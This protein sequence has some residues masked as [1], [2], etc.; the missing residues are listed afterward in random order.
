[1]QTI[2]ESLIKQ[3]EQVLRDNSE[4]MLNRHTNLLEIAIISLYNRLVNRIGIDTEQFRANGAVIAL[5][6]FGRGLIG[7]NEP[8]QI[9]FLTTESLPW[10]ETWTEE[11]HSPLTEAGWELIS[12]Q[13]TMG[14]LLERAGKDFP[15]F[16]KL[17][18]A[19]YV[20][21]SRKITED[22]DKALQSLMEGRQDE[23]LLRLYESVKE[24]Q[25]RL[26]DPA[27]W[28]EPNLIHNPGGLADI[29]AIR[30]ACRIASDIRSLEDA[31]FYGYL[32][33]EDADFLRQAEK[34]YVRLLNLLHDSSENG[35]GTFHFQDQETLAEKLAYSARSGFLPVESFMQHL[36]QL[37]HSVNFIEQEFWERLQESRWD[38]EKEEEV[39]MTELEEGVLVRSGKISLQPAHYTAT[40]SRLIHVFVLAAKHKL[41]FDNNTRGWIQHHQNLLD[42]AA[43]DLMVKEELLEL[44]RSD[45]WDLPLLRRF[46]NRGMLTSLIPELAGVHGLVQHDAFHVYPVH[47]HHLR[48]LTELKKLLQGEYDHEEPELTRIAQKIE[49]PAWLFWAALLHD[50]GK[51]AGRDHAL[52]GGEMIPPIARR[53][54]FTAEESD[55]VRF[56]TAHHPLLRDSASMRHLGD[57]EMLNRCGHII[58]TPERLDLL[59][60][61]SF[62]DM[63]ATGP[64]AQEKWRQTPIFSL[65]EKVRQILEKGEPSHQATQEKRDHLKK[66]LEQKVADFMNHEELETHFEQL[67][68]RYL[69][70]T[71]SDD[72]ARHLRMEYR[73]L[74]SEELFEWEVSTADV[75]AVLTLVSRETPGLL[76]Q[77][78]GVMA[79]HDLNIV[80][81]Q[82]FTKKNGIILLIFHCRLPVGK[83]TDHPHWN[84]VMKDMN[85]LLQ[86][87]LALD[88]RIAAHAAR[89]NH[90][91][92]SVRS[93]PSRVLVD[94]ESSQVYTI[95]EVYTA[96]R[97]GLLY[98][99]AHTLLDLQVRIHVAKITTKGDQAADVFY[100]K[101][102]QGEKISDPE[103]IEEIKNALYFWLDDSDAG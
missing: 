10:E 79:L 5:G 29:L 88:Y 80:E 71:P 96:D 102:R 72:I 12:Q 8:V 48:T 18:E 91:K 32:T 9:L 2:L 68:P 41:D 94:N 42:T 45:A 59:L 60:L 40:A 78:A 54:G 73:F 63:T 84:T 16:L 27:N 13:A 98:S 85:R 95:L 35:S 52:H 97:V 81:A 61:L 25:E 20:S 19:R 37:F 101:T 86:G 31:I 56:L 24:R 43:S 92:T 90:R 58:E 74:H 7:P 23:Y 89:H 82:I 38:R 33:R 49:E 62:A 53:L 44:I 76:V 21:G 36:H 87:K 50:I 30:K 28:L 6:A 3:R 70:S 26:K 77:A 34:K 14:A 75:F 22:F 65:Y 15:F 93:A 99:I 4:E 46:Y 51:A 64:K 100:I 47:E 67:A 17:T 1:M 69:F 11:I 55:T 103:Q 66:V 83:G 39:P 57:E